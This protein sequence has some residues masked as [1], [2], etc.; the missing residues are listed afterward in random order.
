MKNSTNDGFDQ[1]YNVQVAVE[2]GNMFIV[3]NT[4]SNHPVDTYEAI[5]TVDAIPPQVGK[6]EAAAL[7]KIY[8]APE[9]IQAFEARAIDPFIATGREP[10][11]KSWQERLAEAPEPPPDDASPIVKM[12]YKLQT[13]IGQAIY[14]LRKST[15]EPVIGIIKEV[16]GF[17]QFSLRGLGAVAGEWC[18]VCLAWNLKRLHMLAT[19]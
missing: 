6:P 11:H 19:S 4:L 7:D 18:L 1:H 8:F 2:Q 16:L 10:H 3:G 5:P 12:A 15:V 14:R 13:E 9:N 17:R